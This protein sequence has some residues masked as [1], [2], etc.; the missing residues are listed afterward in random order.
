MFQTTNQLG[1]SSTDQQ[2]Y[3]YRLLNGL[4]SRIPGRQ[5]KVPM[6]PCQISQG[7]AES[8]PTQWCAAL[9]VP[10]KWC[11]NGAT[12]GSRSEEKT[13]WSLLW[14][15]GVKHSGEFTRMSEPI[16]KYEK[17]I[18]SIQDFVDIFH[19]GDSQKMMIPRTI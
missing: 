17:S 19:Y 8:A 1:I 3:F 2:W 6:L 13:G 11:G 9:A 15:C 18:R 7:A 4:I 16:F 12:Q 10:S 14:F 5:T